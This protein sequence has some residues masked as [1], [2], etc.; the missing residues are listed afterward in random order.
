MKSATVALSLVAAA[1]ASTSSSSALIPAGISA[2]CTTFLTSFNSDSTLAAC[3]APLISATAQF[4]AT[5]NASAS[6]TSSTVKTALA[7]LCG[8]SSACSPTTIRSTL[9]GMYAACV[10]EL[11]SG[12]NADVLRTY[13]VLYSIVPLA[14]AMCSKDD[15]GDYCVLD[16]SASG[17]SSSSSNSTNDAAASHSS[18]TFSN[19]SQYLWSSSSSSSSSSN[20]SLARRDDSTQTPISIVPNV[21]TFSSNNIL[22]LFLSPDLSSSELCTSCARNVLSAYIDFESTVPYAPGLAVSTLMKGQTALYKSVMNICGENF[23][24]GAAEA[25]GSL[26]GGLL[27]N[28]AHRSVGG[29]GS[30]YVAA[31]AGV[32]AFAM[33]AS[34]V[35]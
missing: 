4:G 18:S 1:W 33:A 5:A 22:F 7:D 34:T 26:S 17:N 10:D 19:I 21:T 12:L 35:L 15:S 24:S 13:D 27:G 29:V 3:T 28:G 6:P 11:T 30:T 9:T 16:I 25:A 32:A 8:A 31:L 23:L 14:N 2:G 20:S